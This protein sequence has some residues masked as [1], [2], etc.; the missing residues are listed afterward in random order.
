MLTES[1]IDPYRAFVLSSC[2][3]T[4]CE[5][6]CRMLEFLPLQNGNLSMLTLV[7]IFQPFPE[8]C[9]ALW[10]IN[11]HFHK[12]IHAWNSS[13]LRY[14]R[15][16][17]TCKNNS[18]S[19]LFECRC[20]SSIGIQSRQVQGALFQLPFEKKIG[21][22]LHVDKPRRANIQTHPALSRALRDGISEARLSTIASNIYLRSINDDLRVGLNARVQ[23][24]KCTK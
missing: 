22:S 8:F 7:Q 13:V 12:N 6:Q 15:I 14:I 19:T 11:L 5:V 2:M 1:Y 4:C 18:P 9:V 21:S 17:A 3:I 10:S 16:I 20:Q 24:G 23:Q